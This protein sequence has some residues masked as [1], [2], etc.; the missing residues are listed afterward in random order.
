MKIKIAT[1]RF[2]VGS[3]VPAPGESA[4]NRNIFFFN[5]IQ[6]LTSYHNPAADWILTKPVLEKCARGWV[7]LPDSRKPLAQLQSPSSS[8][9]R[10][11]QLQSP[12]SVLCCG[13][14]LWNVENNCVY[15]CKWKVFVRSLQ[16]IFKC[17]S[18][19]IIAHISQDDACISPAGLLVPGGHTPV[20]SASSRP[21]P[22]PRPGH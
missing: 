21:R 16:L 9:A 1:T 22:R 18:K 13:S 14:C 20:C 3:P 19:H 6:I 11:G 5:Y 17:R 7:R 12:G 10:R 8:P 4:E 15:A 2:S